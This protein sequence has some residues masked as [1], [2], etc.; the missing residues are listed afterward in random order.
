MTQQLA[1]SRPF[2]LSMLVEIHRVE[3]SLKYVHVDNFLTLSECPP[4]WMKWANACTGPGAGW[5]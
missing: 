2:G 4:R 1:C 3:F 5:A